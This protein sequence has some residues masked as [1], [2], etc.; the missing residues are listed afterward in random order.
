MVG[1]RFEPKLTREGLEQ[2]AVGADDESGPLHRRQLAEKSALDAELRCDGTVLVG[3]KCVVE[4]FHIGEL[5][6]LGDGVVADS[7]S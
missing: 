2:G 6:V 4:G 5:G 7:G 3:K 1:V